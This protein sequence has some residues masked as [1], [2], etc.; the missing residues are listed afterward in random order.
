[1]SSQTTGSNCWLKESVGFFRGT[2]FLLFSVPNPM[3]KLKLDV[4]DVDKLSPTFVSDSEREKEKRA[5]LRIMV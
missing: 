2:I 1:M 3:S 4:E 5:Q